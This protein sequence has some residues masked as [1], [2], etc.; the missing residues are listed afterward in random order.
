[1]RGY[2]IPSGAGV[3]SALGFLTAPASFEL[4]RSVVGP[5]SAERLDEL[6]AVYV[7]LE[8]EGRALLE[9]AGIAPADMVF[10]RQ[11]DL[12]H[13]GQGHE[14]VL[15]LPFASLPGLDLDADVH[16]LFYEAYERV[17]GHAHR[18]LSLEIVTCRLTASGP[19]PELA[20]EPTAVAPAPAEA[21]ILE[22]RPAYFRELGGYVDTPAYERPALTPGATFQG[23][24][25]IEEKDS[26]AVVGP[27]TSV[28]VDPFLNLVVSFD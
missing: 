2:L 11:A 20:L 23:P 15:E 25:I 12:R 16:P 24:A 18:Q 4:A 22:V 17:F 26:T 3:T 19:I 10:V 8:A 1:M 14:I 5:L 21:A 9:E 13:A 28:V 27:G 6:E 7:A